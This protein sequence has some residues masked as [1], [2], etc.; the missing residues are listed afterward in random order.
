MIQLW[1]LSDEYKLF[2]C[3]RVKL[4]LPRNFE[5]LV[6]DH[7]KR[8]HEATRLGLKPGLSREVGKKLVSYC[9]EK[10]RNVYGL[11]EPTG[12]MAYKMRMRFLKQK[13]GR[14]IMVKNAF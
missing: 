8:A 12:R 14:Q 5:T 3:Y 11:P 10:E 2:T 9:F 4:C 7:E 1:G 6:K 13:K